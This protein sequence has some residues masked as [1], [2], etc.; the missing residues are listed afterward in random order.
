MTSQIR[1]IPCRQIRSCNGRLGFQAHD[2]GSVRGSG[3]R[4]LRKRQ[5]A[6][7]GPAPDAGAA[8]RFLSCSC[9]EHRALGAYAILDLLGE[10]GFGTQ[11]PVA[12]RALHFL[13]DH[14]FA[15]K[16]ER[17][18]AFV[19]CAQPGERH[20][21]AFLICRKCDAVAEVNAGRAKGALGAA[22]RAADFHIEKTIVEVEGL[23]PTCIENAA[24]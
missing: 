10:A 19:A 7:T 14:G 12:Y 23:C 8:A 1:S 16:I 22:A 24:A 4:M 9:K 3:D 5:C 11:P 15:H 21:P 20:S 17:L 13:T 18:N 6:R 2:H